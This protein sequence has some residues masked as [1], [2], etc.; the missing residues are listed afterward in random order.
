MKILV[1]GCT[2]RIGSEVLRELKNRGA[3]V[4]VHVRKKGA[5]LP[6]GTGFAVGDLPTELEQVSAKQIA[7]TTDHNVAATSHAT[8][9]T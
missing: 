9:F 2:G 7:L 1:T 8:T 4:R 3:D 6:D 5:S